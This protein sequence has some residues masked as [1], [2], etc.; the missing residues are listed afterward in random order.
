[1]L[2]CRTSLLPL[3]L[4]VASVLAGCGAGATARS[5]PTATR[6]TPARTPWPKVSPEL[7]ELLEKR[8][9]QR[10][11]AVASGRTPPSYGPIE[12]RVDFTGEP[13]RL[14]AAGIP[15]GGFVDDVAQG[16]LTPEQIHAAVALDWVHLVSIP[17]P[18][19]IN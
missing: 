12:V 18:V 16:G 3:I 13:G 15:L 5:E 10:D 9:R 14:V 6:A 4:G 1:M 8:E 19:Q 7:W 2:G 17:T 11:A